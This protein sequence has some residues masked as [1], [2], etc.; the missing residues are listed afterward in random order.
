[1]TDR[2]SQRSCTG[3]CLALTLNKDNPLLELLFLCE[4][5]RV[6]RHVGNTMA[7]FVMQTLGCDVAALNTVQ[8]SRLAPNRQRRVN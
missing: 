8:F 7:A 3:E 2:A 1:M 5:L 4:G 6:S